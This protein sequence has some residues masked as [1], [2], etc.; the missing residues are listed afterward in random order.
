[1]E[2]RTDA[3]VV[4]ETLAGNR[5]AFETLI[6][7]YGRMGYALAFSRLGNHEEAED[8]AQEAWLQAFSNLDRLRNSAQFPAWF[9]AIV[10]NVSINAA[11]NRWRKQSL[12]AAE[13][14]LMFDL[15]KP[16]E[17][18]DMH[19]AL[20]MQV[21][22]MTPEF[23]EVLTLHYHAGLGVDEMA[24]AIGDSREAVKKRLQ[25]A[26]AALSG[27]T[28]QSLLA[29]AERDEEERRK[30]VMALVLITPA[31]WKRETQPAGLGRRPKG[32]LKNITKRHWRRAILTVLGAAAISGLALW[33]THQSGIQKNDLP[34]APNPIPKME[35]TGGGEQNTAQSAKKSFETERPTK[36]KGAP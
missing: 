35:A 21:E 4:R 31:H 29:P 3:E 34:S 7:R 32:I 26:R 25:R 13:G 18:A 15:R 27:Q 22:T 6:L 17:E 28:L 8:A 9:A 10:R 16:L 36:G 23:R 1:M 24:Q 19:R 30:R 11:R 33:F 5:R 2:T 12:E 20:W 14:T